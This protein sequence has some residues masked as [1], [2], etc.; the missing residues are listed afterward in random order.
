MNSNFEQ[1]LRRNPVRPDVAHMK[2]DNVREAKRRRQAPNKRLPDAHPVTKPA[3]QTS[4]SRMQ[5]QQMKSQETLIRMLAEQPA[6]QE[7]QLITEPIEKID[8]K[9]LATLPHSSLKTLA[10]NLRKIKEEI[11]KA[12]EQLHHNSQLKSGLHSVNKAVRGQLLE[13]L[14]KKKDLIKEKLDLI[15]LDFE[16]RSQIDD[17]QEAQQT[18]AESRS[19]KKQVTKD[20]EALQKRLQKMTAF[21]QQVDESFQAL[22]KLRSLKMKV[23]KKYRA[24]NKQVPARLVRAFE[25]ERAVRIKEAKQNLFATKYPEQVK[26][27]KTLVD[28]FNRKVKTRKYQNSSLFTSREI[29]A[30]GEFRTKAQ[31]IIKK[32]TWSHKGE[33]QLRQIPRALVQADSRR[34]QRS[35]KPLT[36]FDA[37]RS[38]N[39]TKQNRPELNPKQKLVSDFNSLVDLFRD[40][41]SHSPKAFK[42]KFNHAAENSNIKKFF[43]IERNRFLFTD[44][45]HKLIEDQNNIESGLT[46]FDQARLESLRETFQKHLDT[47]KAIANGEGL[48]I[49]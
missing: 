35:E 19:K 18:Q 9:F 33:P 27:L 4:L 6:S 47:R 34:S 21:E 28:K 3:S 26:N 23:P 31:S 16:R 17:V 41:V 42:Q 39:A 7:K 44:A 25:A 22:Q 2:G 29:A 36:V 48:K 13:E 24:K 8:A 37:A 40:L 1:Y 15:D 11:H 45:A 20:I 32:L 49:A 43:Q 46:E 12:K 5:E 30:L 14:D 38:K 10:K